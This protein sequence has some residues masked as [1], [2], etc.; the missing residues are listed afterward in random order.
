MDQHFSGKGYK[1]TQKFKPIDGE[2]IDVCN[3]FLK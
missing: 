3:G 1:V 2:I